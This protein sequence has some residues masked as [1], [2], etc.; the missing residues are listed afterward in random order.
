M[1]EH[2]L[3]H[4]LMLKMHDSAYTWLAC[5]RCIKVFSKSKHVSSPVMASIA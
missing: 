5:Q 2:V 1:I 3:T 4:R